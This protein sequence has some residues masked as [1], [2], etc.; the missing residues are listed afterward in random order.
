MAYRIPVTCKCEVGYYDKQEENS[1]HTCNKCRER[2]FDC[3]A[4]D[5]S[6]S[7]N[8]NNRQ[9]VDKDCICKVTFYE[10]PDDEH[11]IPC[12]YPCL[13]CTTDVICKCKQ[14]FITI[15]VLY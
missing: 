4:K 5:I 6:L 14:I 1:T 9:P 15:N 3:S 13:D 7:C 2:Y 12:V 8:G 11:C 10:S